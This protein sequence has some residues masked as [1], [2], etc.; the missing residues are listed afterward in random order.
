MRGPH[1]GVLCIALLCA[2][3][4]QSSAA[5]PGAGAALYLEGRLPDGQ[6]LQ[7]IGPNGVVARGADAA[8]VNCHRRS[9]LG[10]REGDITVPPLTAAYLFRDGATNA[11]DAAL[12]HPPG[13]TPRSFAYTPETLLQTLVSG[14]RPD[15]RSLRAP[16]PHYVLDATAGRALTDYL[17]SLGVA[18]APGVGADEIVFATIVTPDAEPVAREAMLTVLRAYF[19]T[20]AE[21]AAARRD[22]ARPNGVAPYRATRRWRLQ[23]WALSGPATDW[24]RQ[25][26]DYQAQD[27]AFALLSGMA[28]RDWAPVHAFCEQARVPCLF[29]NV[30]LPV[31]AEQDF[32][33]LYYS[34]GVLLEAELLRARAAGVRRFVQLYRR[35]DIGLAAANALRAHAAGVVVEDRVLPA[36]ATTLQA[37]ATQLAHA[38]D[39]IGAEAATLLW[40][41]GDDLRALGNPP[42]GR[43]LASG[44]MAGLDDAPLPARWRAR[45]EFAYPLDLPARRALRMRFPLAWLKAHDIPVTALRV[46]SD[47]WLAC[48]ILAGILEHVGDAYVPEY[49]VERLETMLGRR[50]S[51]GYYPRLGLAPGQRFASKGGALVRLAEDGTVVPVVDWLVP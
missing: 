51:D 10:S 33:P 30:D 4:A 5:P 23:V 18:P 38:L 20:Q 35:D 43:I 27:P 16:M 22:E 24:Q 44:L 40:L 12:A 41:R 13:T 7:A 21:A 8:C 31:V 50:L 9:G 45:T 2:A 37:R 3:A 36:A 28:G 39:G 42:P 19:A 6:P 11:A 25:L 15:G 49:L 46:Q 1:L 14:V 17:A 48:D 26:G 32:Y 29:P 34:R 47:S